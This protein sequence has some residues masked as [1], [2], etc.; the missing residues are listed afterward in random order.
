MQNKQ[1]IIG[2]VAAIVILLGAGSVYLLN[3][4]K[5]VIQ[6]A[7]TSTATQQTT[8]SNNASQSSLKD[9]FTMGSNKKCTFDTKTATSETTGTFYVSGTNARG[10]LATTTNGKTSSTNLVRNNDTFYI[11]GDSLPSGVKMT[12]SVD[13]MASK[14]NGG[15]YS[16]I[17]PNEKVDFKCDNWT[18]DSSLFTPP[19]SIKFMDMGNVMTSVTGTQAQTSPSAASQCNLCSSLTGAAK[20]SCMTSFHCQ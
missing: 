7:A 13:E 6:P 3:K 14:M 2:I 5:T 17:N 15:Q 20:T 19:A 16:S 12:M 18:V 8:S 11:W 4:N 10:D 1:A 9:L